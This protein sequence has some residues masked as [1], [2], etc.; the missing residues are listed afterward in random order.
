[1]IWRLPVLWHLAATAWCAVARRQRRGGGPL[2]ECPETRFQRSWL[3]RGS[4]HYPEHH[5]PAEIPERFVSLA[6][7]LAA[8]NVDV[9]VAANRLDALAAQRA[10]STIPI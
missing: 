8:L 3:C 1:M 6:V 7:E 4:K 9:L 10:T 5:F 2:P